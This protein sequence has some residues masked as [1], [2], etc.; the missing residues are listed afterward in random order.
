MKLRLLFF[1]YFNFLFVWL[2]LFSLNCTN[3]K[4]KIKYCLRNSLLRREFATRQA[5][6][7]LVIN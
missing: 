4:D 1:S 5:L 6:C 7:A 2:S 3:E